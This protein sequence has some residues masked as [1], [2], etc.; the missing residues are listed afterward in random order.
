M[1]K[2]TKL[3]RKHTVDIIKI[4]TIPHLGGF[5]VAYNFYHTDKKAN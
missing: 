3:E 1:H 2:T 5:P 4:F